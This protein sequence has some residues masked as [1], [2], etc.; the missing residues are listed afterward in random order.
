VDPLNS[1]VVG[2]PDGEKLKILRLCDLGKI[3]TPVQP[4]D[5]SGKF[6]LVKPR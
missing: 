3:S 2:E 4:T 1:L 6:C 5:W